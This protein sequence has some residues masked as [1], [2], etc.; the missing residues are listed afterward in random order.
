M[1]P[2]IKSTNK[3]FSV[4]GKQLTRDEAEDM[5]YK[6][7]L[8]EIVYARCYDALETIVFEGWKG[9]IEWS[10]KDLQEALDQLIE[11][12]LKGV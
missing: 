12:N 9:V 4:F 11:G 6:D 5:I 8:A 1:I 3:P 2:M 7:K 10:D